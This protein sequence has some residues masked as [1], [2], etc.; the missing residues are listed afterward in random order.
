M[1]KRMLFVFA[2]IILSF[3]AV[4]ANQKQVLIPFK[5]DTLDIYGFKDSITDKII[6]PA[7]F[8]KVSS[9]NDGLAAVNVG[10]TTEIDEENDRVYLEGGQWGFINPEGK[11]VIPAKYESVSPF[12]N[13]TAIVEGVPELDSMYRYGLINTKGGYVIPLM[14][15]DLSSIDD[16]LYY[17]TKNNLQGII[18]NAGKVCIP[19]QYENIECYNG[20]A[21]VKKDTLEGIIKMNNT[22]VVPIQN[23]SISL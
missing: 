11:F 7:Q 15:E 23:S 16:N 21:I 1:K 17:A 8:A 3:S 18:D 12:S 9:F 2:S 4:A 10:G 5:S 6:I 20:F 19:L 22:L 14:Y 13:G